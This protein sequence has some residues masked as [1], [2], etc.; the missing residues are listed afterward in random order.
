MM[1]A[2]EPISS[3]TKI[4]KSTAKG[5]GAVS[6]EKNIKTSL[7]EDCDSTPS[8]FVE[9]HSFVKIVNDLIDKKLKMNE[10]ELE[11]F[12][13]VVRICRDLQAKT[14]VMLDRQVS[15]AASAPGSLFGRNYPSNN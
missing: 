6:D 10:R 9:R 12:L 2:E 5:A 11:L 14:I 15:R 7:D 4:L 13:A 3:T 1:S 8:Y